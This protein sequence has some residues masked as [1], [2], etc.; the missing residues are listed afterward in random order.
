M[1]IT[2]VGSWLPT[3]D[4]F[5]THWLA[6]NVALSPSEMILS[7][8][9]D[10][11][12]LEDDRAALV[13]VLG[14]VTAKVNIL[15][16]SA[17]DRDIKRAGIRPRM[18]QFRQAVGGQLP[19]SQ[20]AK[21]LPK[22]PRFSSS[23]GLWRE[24]MTDMLTLWTTINTNVPPIAGFAPPL[25]LGGPYAVAA[26]T[27]EKGAMD[28]AFTAVNVN[29]QVLKQT[30]RSR[31]ATFEPIYERL[32]QYRQ[33]VIGAL[34]V[35]NALLDS[36]PRLTP[37]PGS[38]PPPTNLSGVW[39]AG[40]TEADLTWEELAL[41]NF[42]YWSIRAHPGP[43]WRNDEAETIGQV[44][45]PDLSFSTDHGLVASGSMQLFAVFTVVTT[46]NERRSNV[47]KVI[48]P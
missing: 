17:G 16:S 32:K 44:F 46:G 15:T 43:K 27:T 19:G 10:E 14:T 2:S 33:A 48:R 24:A 34:P 26:Y 1:P 8:G 3:I 18:M 7:G 23:P 20:H 12:S 9:Y 4:E 31:D 28:S 39:N 5:K 30:R 40:T 42:D 22:T 35:G 11:P 29:E 21:S 25:V 47:V 37:P 6:V 38:T 36:I 13:L 45:S 41:P